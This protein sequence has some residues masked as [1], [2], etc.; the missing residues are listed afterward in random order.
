MKRPN[1]FQFNNRA[2]N[3]FA[4]SIAVKALTAL[5]DRA[6]FISEVIQLQNIVYSLPLWILFGQDLGEA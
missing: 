2:L 4:T 6:L 5:A 3:R 1:E